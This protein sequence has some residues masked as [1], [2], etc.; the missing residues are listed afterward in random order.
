MFGADVYYIDFVTIYL[1]I[2]HAAGNTIYSVYEQQSGPGTIRI[3]KRQSSYE[4]NYPPDM[5]IPPQ[6]TMPPGK[7]N[8]VCVYVSLKITLSMS[9][10]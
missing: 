9:A 5:D 7:S 4:T 8:Q 2:Y 1:S 10:R 6:M 3:T